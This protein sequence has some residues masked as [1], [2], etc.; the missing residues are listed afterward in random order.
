MS[1]S[2]RHQWINK[3]QAPL[4]DDR[5]QKIKNKSSKDKFLLENLPAL[6]GPF[7]QFRVYGYNFWLKQ[8]PKTRMAIFG[9]NE[10]DPFGSIVK[11]YCKRTENTDFKIYDTHQLLENQIRVQ[12]YKTVIEVICSVHIRERSIVT[13]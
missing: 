1:D 7:R 11:Q 6:L 13:V 2:I 8:Q 4:G 3:C 9:C 12:H 10:K 5:Y